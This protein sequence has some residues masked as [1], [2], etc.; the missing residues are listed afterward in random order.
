MRI[1]ELEAIVGVPKTYLPAS[2]HE[3][4]SGRKQRTENISFR[5]SGVYLKLMFSAD[6]PNWTPAED[7]SC[8]RVGAQ[9]LLRISG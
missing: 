3:A 1:N 5:Y 2:Y 4:G 8:Y 9:D 7:C 6:L